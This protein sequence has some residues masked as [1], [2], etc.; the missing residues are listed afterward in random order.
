MV[1]LELTVF[2][3]QAEELGEAR[4]AGTEEARNPDADAVVRLVRGFQVAVEDGRIEFADRLGGDILVDLL[5]DDLLVC[6]IDLN[7]LL[8]A[9]TDVAREKVLD[10]R[11]GHG[12]FLPQKILG[13]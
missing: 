1:I 11:Q 9:A 3:G 12:C 6:R 4:L 8:D 5:A 13:R 10:E 7:D 2:E